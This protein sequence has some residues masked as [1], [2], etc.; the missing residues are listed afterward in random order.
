MSESVNQNI[1]KETEV[2]AN[3]SLKPKKVN[4]RRL[5]F[6]FFAAA[7]VFI[8]L[9]ALGIY[10]RNTWTAKLQLRTNQAAQ[11]VVDV[12]HPEK[13]VGIIH[14]ELPG[15]TMPY[16]DAP[17]FAQTSGYLKKWYFDIGAKVKAGAILAE[18]D[19]PEVDQQLA[20]AQAQ[21]KVA[22]AACNLA[23]VTY[24]R[25]QTLFK[26]NVIAAQDFDT[27]ADN[28]AGSQ[29]TVIVDQAIVNRLQALEAFKTVRAPFDGIVTARN[30]DI[31]A[32][33]PSG[34]G[35][36]L[37]RMAR[38]SPLR[39]YVV[40]PQAFSSLVK[41]GE[42]AELAVNEYPGRTFPAHVVGT[43]GAINS[44]TKRLLT[45]LDAPN[46]TGELLPGSYAQVTLQL[47][48]DNGGVMIP[49]RTL[50]FQSGSPAVGVVLPDGK[51][52]IRKVSITRDLGNRLE[53]SKGLSESDQIIV[54]PSS[55]LATGT[56]VTIAN[57]A[58]GIAVASTGPNT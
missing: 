4:R 28:Y 9:A 33:V 13:A 50:L 2:P 25:D 15:Q 42:E 34:S 29:S 46:S 51:V 12:T 58:S 41:V 1:S 3:R 39:V 45:E 53:I 49:P 47:Q 10:A 31:G 8:G 57:P 16:T 37:F 27:A 38:N 32:F 19:T 23:E 21:L 22:Q 26:T 18:I 56:A 44:T 30:T 35:T 40:V 20:Q 11:M 5:R 52:E 36:Q 48:T 6:F 43:A 7:A 24:Q 17:I 55:G 14:L 54:N